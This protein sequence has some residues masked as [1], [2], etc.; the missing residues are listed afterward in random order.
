LDSGSS[1]RID[2]DGDGKVMRVWISALENQGMD[3]LRQ[4]IE[5]FFT[6]DIIRKRLSLMP[7]DGKLRAK[8]FDQSI[9]LEEKYA[10]NGELL[11]DF[12]CSSEQYSDFCRIEGFEE[13]IV[14]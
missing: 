11:I 4:A 12:E 8:L 6:T 5:D 13:K 7:T 2:R 1:A 10:E 3:F 9:V 14:I